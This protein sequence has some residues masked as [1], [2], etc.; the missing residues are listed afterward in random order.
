MQLVGFIFSIVFKVILFLVGFLIFVFGV[1]LSGSE[2]GGVGEFLFFSTISIIVFYFSF[3]KKIKHGCAWCGSK[4]LKLVDKDVSGWI[5][6]YRNKDESKD[7]RVKGNYQVA[8]MR[9]YWECKKCTALTR[10]QHNPTRKPSTRDSI[11]TRMLAKEGVGERRASN[12]SVK[13]AR[14]MAGE[15]RKAN[16]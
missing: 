15:N 11:V 8:A 14:S 6:N 16:K 1:A 12:Y 13:G 3:R 7:K 10:Y 4:K 5:W 2:D 9:S